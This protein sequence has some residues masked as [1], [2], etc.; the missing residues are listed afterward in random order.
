MTQ[1]IQIQT[2]TAFSVDFNANGTSYRM[3]VAFNTHNNSYYFDLFMLRGMKK[4]L[5]GVPFSTG[6]NLLSQFPHWFQLWVV[7]TKPELY[8]SNPK[9]ETIQSYQIWVEDGV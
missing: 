9:A 3:K 1:I 2:N 4:L 7:P 5:S 6:T 8:A